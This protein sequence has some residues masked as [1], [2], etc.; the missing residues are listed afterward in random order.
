MSTLVLP[1]V[2]GVIM[3][4]LFLYIFA[5]FG[6]LTGTAGGG[7]SWILPALIPAAALIGWLAALRLEKADPASFARMGQNRA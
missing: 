5:N 4:A 7:L 6:D 2:S 3:A 1:A